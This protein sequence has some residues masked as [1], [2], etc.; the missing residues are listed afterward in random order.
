MWIDKKD[1][2]L[3]SDSKYH[4][5]RIHFYDEFPVEDIKKIRRFGKWLSGKYWFPIRCNIYI[6]AQKKFQSIDD[7]HV[8]YGIFY[9]NE[10]NRK[11]PCICI[12]NE[13]KN[14][15]DEYNC[16]FAIVHELTHYFQWYFYELEN[17]SS[18]SSEIMAN[19]WARYITCEYLN[20]D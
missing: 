13:F 14:S 6:V 15:D 8:Y 4:G 12:A 5:I 18:R 17:K 9:S 2:S 20:T 11:Y 19:K 16:Y 3:Y 1:K 10:D 7:G